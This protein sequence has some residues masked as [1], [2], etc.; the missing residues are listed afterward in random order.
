MLDYY[1]S[2]FRDLLV[3]I[4]FAIYFK[5]SFAYY[6]VACFITYFV[7]YYLLYVVYLI[8]LSY[9]ILCRN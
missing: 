9:Y 2:I 4:V 1:C 7:Y 8:N 5:Q 3:L 6:F